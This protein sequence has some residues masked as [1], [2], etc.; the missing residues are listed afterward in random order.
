M[1]NTAAYHAATRSPERAAHPARGQRRAVH[2]SGTACADED[3][4]HAAARLQELR[5]EVAIDLLAQP[6]H[7]H[8][9]DVRAR[10]ERVVPDAR[11][12]HRLRHDLAGVPGE[13][14]EQRELARPEVDGLAAARH[15]RE[16]RSM[17][18]S[19]TSRCV[20]SARSGRRAGGP[21]ARAPAARRTQTAWSGSRRRRSAGPRT[22]SSTDRFALRMMTG[23]VRPRRRRA[24]ISE[25]PS[26][27]G[28]MMSTIA[29]SGRCPTARS[30]P[31]LPSAATSTAYPASRSAVGDE[32]R[33]G[34]I[35]FDD[36][37][38]HGGLRLD[39]GHA[40]G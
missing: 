24:S 9:D 40:R 33:Q 39:H 11:Q 32:R 8:V 25:K 34:R 21:P 30:R 28:S 23:I 35:V 16:S 2:H 18:R 4:A 10:I 13:E 12:D 29:R 27:S 14:L 36:Q 6:A 38:A 22:R 5:L 20:G 1:T 17:R 7:E 37:N 31:R 26:S 3:V 15:R 19:P